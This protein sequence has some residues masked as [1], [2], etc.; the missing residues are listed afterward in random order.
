[1]H[2]FSSSSLRS[3]CCY[4]ASVE[5][6]SRKYCYTRLAKWECGWHGVYIFHFGGIWQNDLAPVW[7]FVV[8]TKAGIVLV[9]TQLWNVAEEIVWAKSTKRQEYS[10]WWSS[11][12]QYTVTK[13]CI[14]SSSRPRI[15]T[16]LNTVNAKPRYELRWYSRQCLNS[17]RCRGRRFQLWLF[18]MHLVQYRNPITLT[19]RGCVPTTV[20]IYLIRGGMAWHKTTKR[21]K[22]PHCFPFVKYKPFIQH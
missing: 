20:H 1:M 16:S 15:Q 10:R 18:Q 21:M 4:N 8:R 22:Y 2:L 19:E 11:F 17:W 14:N 9:W 6:L 12:F 5:S 13:R 3:V 7:S